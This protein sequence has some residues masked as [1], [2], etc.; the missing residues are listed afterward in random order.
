LKL[1]KLIYKFKLKYN[2]IH[3]SIKKLNKKSSFVKTLIE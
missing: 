2:E 3:R 1:Y